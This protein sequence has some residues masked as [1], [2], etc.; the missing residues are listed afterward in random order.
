[1]KK[2]AIIMAVLMLAVTVLASCSSEPSD[3]PDGMRRITS[4][5]LGCNLHVPEDWTESSFTTNAV[6]AY[7]SNSDPTNVTVM[8][9]NVDATETLDSWWAKYR[10][11]FD[12]VFDEFKLESTDNTTLGG[13]AAVR[14]T[15]TAKLGDIEYS[16]VQCA[17]LHWGMVYVMTFTSIP[18]YSGSHEEEYSDIIGY[19]EFL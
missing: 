5:A 3:I 4:E 9:W 18:E 12:L 10:E 15:Y 16:Y 13:V 7:C 1:M 11:D 19:F 2:L 17:C 14:Y 8:A 6:G